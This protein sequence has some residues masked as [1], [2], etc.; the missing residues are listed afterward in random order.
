MGLKALESNHEMHYVGPL[1]FD[2]VGLILMPGPVLCVLN[3]KTWVGRC[4]SR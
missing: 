4:W 2:T 1:M 3:D